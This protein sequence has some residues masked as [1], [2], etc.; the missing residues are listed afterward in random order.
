MCSKADTSHFAAIYETFGKHLL[1]HV[2]QLTGGSKFLLPFNNGCT[3]LEFDKKAKTIKIFLQNDLKL[4][5]FEMLQVDIGIAIHV[6]QYIEFEQNMKH[7]DVLISTS[8][9]Q[10][11][12]HNFSHLIFQNMS[13]NT[14]EW[15]KFDEVGVLNILTLS[16]QTYFI[17]E[18]KSQDFM[19]KIMYQKMITKCCRILNY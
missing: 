11:P 7:K 9:S 4:L 18:F 10:P 16:E 1:G 3:K 17:P 2:P 19:E 14:I 6:A 8:I 5:P 15:S 12:W 13:S